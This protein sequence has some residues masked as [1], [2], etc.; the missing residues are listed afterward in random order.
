[1]M[2]KLLTPL[3]ASGV[4]YLGV[5]A[6]FIERLQAR[7]AEIV[8]DALAIIPSLLA[9]LI[10]L[11][12]TR[13]AVMFVDRTAPVAIGKVVKSK[14]LQSLFVK[15]CRVSTW[16]AGILIVCTIAFPD[17][18]VGDLIGLLG[19]GSVAIGFAF[20]DIFKN[21]LAGILLLLNEPFKIGDEIIVES[22]SGKVEDISIRTTAVRT[23]QG[24]LVVLPNS[25]LFTNPVT[26]LTERPSRR[27]DLAIGVDYNTPLPLAR[28]VFNKTINGLEGVL[29]DP[30]PE[31]DA[32]GFGDSSIDFLVRYWTMPK[33]SVVRQTR[34]KA[35]FALKAAC[36]EAGIAIPYP[37]RTVYRFDQEQ[38]DDATPKA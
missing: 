32:V 2:T 28:D 37:I 34:S 11:F 19:L 12:L 33:T 35:I 30:V 18:R 25:V 36:D 21:F 9:A 16:A 4:D 10:V 5:N 3:A 1:M 23:Y 20:Q 8:A 17:L 15:L 6:E 7:L 38:F 13:Y 31:I 22:Y 29:A 26:V 14:S 24:E 27:T